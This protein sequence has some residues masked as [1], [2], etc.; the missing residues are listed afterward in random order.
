MEFAFFGTY[1]KRETTR[2]FKDISLE[3]IAQMSPELAMAIQDPE[4]KEGV[5]E[6]LFPLFPN[7][8]KR[9]VRK[10]INELRNKGVSKV[11]TEKAVVN[12]PAIKA[13]ELGREIIIDSNVIDL[14]SARSI[15]CIHY[16]S[17]RSSH[18]EGQRRMG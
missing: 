2:V 4:M 17:S 3:E 11:P 1:W 12:R 7:L 8:K 6:M 15:H 18:A 10:M 13:Y 9:R 5:E 14:E 16:Y